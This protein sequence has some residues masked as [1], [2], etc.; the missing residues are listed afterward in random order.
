MARKSKDIQQRVALLGGTSSEYLGRRPLPQ[1][2]VSRSFVLVLGPRGVGKTS[3][4][5]RVLG[6][7]P[8]VLK[9]AA[10]HDAAASAVRRGRWP[11]EVLDAPDLLI[12]GPTLLSRR[13]G[14]TRL[15][16]A[17]IRERSGRGHRT[18]VC[19]G[20]GDDS[21]LLLAQE[22]EVQNQVT[23]NLRYPQ[24]RG[25]IRFA[26]RVCEELGIDRRYARLVQPEDRWTY[27][28]VI[29]ALKKIKRD[30]GEFSAGS[31]H[32]L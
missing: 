21:V 20:D 5:K 31:G 7:N 17:L 25:R 11:L 8:L 2:L 19:Q 10:L 1:L 30:G 29:R 18:A 23:L 9:G 16:Q 22:S 3:V 27:L 6:K 14:V 28:K 12:D 32:G 24:G 13:P 15:L 26:A 4:A